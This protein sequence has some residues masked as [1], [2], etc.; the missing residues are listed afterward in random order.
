M[1]RLM[2]ILLLLLPLPALAT[3]PPIA[4]ISMHDLTLAREAEVL[5]VLP[6]TVGDPYTPA[7]V[8][9]AL[10]ILRAWGLFTRVEAAVDRTP[11]GMALHFHFTE[12]RLIGEINIHGNYPFIENRIR[13]HLTIRP[14]DPFDRAAIEAQI[15]RLKN[16]YDREGYHDTTITATEEWQPYGSEMRVD[17]HIRKGTTYTIGTVTVRGNTV[18]PTG[19]FI[20]AMNPWRTYTPRRAR[21][22]VAELTQLYRKRHYPKARIRLVEETLDPRFHEVN[23]TLAVEEGPH[24]TVVYDGNRSVS[25]HEC[26][27]ALTIF[28]EGRLD[29]FELEASAAGIRKRY[30]QRGFPHAAVAFERENISDQEI[31]VRFAID[32]GPRQRVRRVDFQG[33]ATVGADTLRG[34]VLTKPLS[35]FHKGSFDPELLAEDTKVLEQFYRHA[36]YLQ[37]KVAEPIVASHPSEAAL[38]VTI[39]LTEGGQYRIAEVRFEG[40]IHATHEA[41]LKSCQLKPGV[42]ADLAKSDGDREAVRLYFADRGFPYA[43]VE[44]TVTV[45]DAATE[46]SIGYQITEGEFVRIGEIVI[47]GDFLTS[48]RT[49]RRAMTVK[50]GDPYSER[51]IIESQ[52]GI[53]RLGAFRTVATEPV[54]LHPGTTVVP[55]RV[56]VEEEK[57]HV[58]DIDAGYSTDQGLTG[59]LGYTNINSFGWAKRTQFRLTGGREFSRGELGWIDPRFLGRDLQWTTNTWLQY[60]NKA[61]FDYVQAGG[62]F[63]LFRQFHRFGFYTRY[64]LER[65][66]FLAG[67]SAAADAESLRDNTISTVGLGASFDTRNNFA[68]PTRGI[69]V[70]GGADFFNEIKGPQANFVHLHGGISHHWAPVKG[71]VLSQYGRL[72][73]ITPFGDNVSVPSNKLLFL[74]GDYT[75]RGF[76]EESI[77]PLDAAGR[78]TGGRIRWIYNAEV[79]ARLAN[80]FKAVGFFDIGSLTNAFRDISNATTRESIGFGLR[81]MTPVGPLRADYGFK[82]DRQPGESVGRFHFTFGHLF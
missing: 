15:T 69:F 74:G 65:N 73:G 6:F 79:T 10:R 40:N 26:T 68:D 49:I 29:E 24:V 23:L 53:R 11:E 37:A 45:N 55:L 5:A 56:R 57:P 47:V 48:Q 22:A 14:G 35:F 42:P 34:E 30:R 59:S 41:L 13:R 43:T 27:K 20:S 25:D 31:V 38:D 58:V 9:E 18:F 44:Q 16:F 77:G 3:P 4:A 19:R 21:A 82:L 1:C 54:E 66:Y 78:A 63:G 62:G 8:E 70:S 80:G 67:D 36:G 71:L 17:F 33:N 64:K 76:A 32:E 7:A 81:Y 46:V 12:A 72:A 61:A 39:P 51:K 28:A 75:I 2:S 60:E 52:Q 50:P